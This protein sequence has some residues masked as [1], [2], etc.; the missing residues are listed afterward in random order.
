MVARDIDGG[1]RFLE[2]ILD[3]GSAQPWRWRA[4]ALYGD[5]V[6][7]MRQGRLEESRKRS[8]ETL[9]IAELTKDV[10][11]LVMEILP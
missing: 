11:A 1:R 8:Q 4:L 10:E 7:A 2:E 3:R 9:R 6:L 5:S